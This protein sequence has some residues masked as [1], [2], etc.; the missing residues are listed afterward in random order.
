MDSIGI[1]DYVQ[2][3]ST[4]TQFLSPAQT[5]IQQREMFIPTELLNCSHVFIRIDAVR[6]PL[7][8]PY[9]GPLVELRKVLQG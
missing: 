9:E 5:G 7:Q 2:R 6:K 3:L 4:F 8:Q 1:Q